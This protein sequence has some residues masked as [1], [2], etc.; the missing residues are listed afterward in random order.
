MIQAIVNFTE[1]ILN[2]ANQA[3][4]AVEALLLCLFSSEGQGRATKAKEVGACPGFIID[5]AST[6]YNFMALVTAHLMQAF[7]IDRG[8]STLSNDIINPYVVE[9]SRRSQK[10]RQHKA[11]KAKARVFN[12]KC[13]HLIVKNFIKAKAFVCIR[14]AEA[15]VGSVDSMST[16][17]E[18]LSSK[19]NP[20]AYCAVNYTNLLSDCIAGVNVRL[21]RLS[22]RKGHRVFRFLLGF[23]ISH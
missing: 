7:A 9:T 22:I 18:N 3:A 4:G 8:R 14:I 13:T 19:L 2:L 10:K 21:S 12:G 17:A 1:F 5:L 16:V 23:H 6:V 20:Q 11:Q 15:F